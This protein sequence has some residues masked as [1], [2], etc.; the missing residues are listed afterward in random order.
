MNSKGVGVS[1]FVLVIVDF[2]VAFGMVFYYAAG[3]T[4]E[5]GITEN[6]IVS[7]LINITP[8]LFM[9]LLGRRKYGAER[10]FTDVLGFRHIKISTALMTIL[11]TVLVIPLSTLANM[12]S[13]I[14]VDNVVGELAGDVLDVPFAIMF[15]LMAVFGPFCEEAVF[16][17]AFFRGLRKSGNIFGAVIM[18][19]LLFAAMHLNLNQAA[20]AFVLG[21]MMALAA[22]ATG[23][24]M[25]SFIMHLIFNGQSVCLMYLSDRFLPGFL[26]EELQM[27]Y[28]AREMFLTLSTYLQ[29][30]LA[31][32]VLA[33]C[34]LSWMAA[35][36][37]RR[38]F[39]KIVWASRK[40]HREKIGSVW[41]VM[42]LMLA[43]VYMIA[44]ASFT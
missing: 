19:S 33:V 16:R 8:V 35:N 43:F 32:T 23:S 37:G 36:E 28:T 4:G 11:Y 25:T 39:L 14:F 9:I 18:S 2:L 6:L 40:N 30:S 41:L 38:H 7:Q 13:M 20:Y 21:I 3:G 22:E 29:I 15:L 34:V 5:I 26:E 44:M 12:I 24:T 1:F 42:G 17:G 31:C 27:D 10:V